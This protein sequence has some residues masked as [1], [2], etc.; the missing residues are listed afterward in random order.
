MSGSTLPP[1]R[2]SSRAISYSSAPP[3]YLYFRDEHLV[4]LKPLIF[5]DDDLPH[6]WPACPR[7]TT[8]TENGNL[9]PDI[10]ALAADFA[11]H[12][13]SVIVSEP[14]SPDTYGDD[15][16]R[17]MT[18]EEFAALW[19]DRADERVYLK[20]FH[21]CLARPHDCMYRTYDLFQGELS[22]FTVRIKFNLHV[23]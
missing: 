18:F 2:T 20:D 3:S 6:D 8:E 1:P 23:M 12:E 19:K 21:L 15:G 10:D 5:R 11:G 14:G 4:P 22:M 17:T 9:E 16:R 13:V 7:W